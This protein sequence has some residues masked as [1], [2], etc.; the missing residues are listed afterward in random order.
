M[1]SCVRPSTAVPLGIGIE[2]REAMTEY[3]VPGVTNAERNVVGM[4]PHPERAADPLLGGA[5]GAAISSEEH[6][7]RRQQIRASFERPLWLPTVSTAV[8]TIECAE[9]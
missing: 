4:M 1:P 2:K 9:S 8:M 3:S 5:P 7:I 6:R